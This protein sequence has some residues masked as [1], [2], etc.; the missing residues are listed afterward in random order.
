M[1]KNTSSLSFRRLNL[2]LPNAQ[3]SVHN[4]SVILDMARFVANPVHP[5]FNFRFGGGIGT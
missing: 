3:K 5:S 2:D 4:V 1:V